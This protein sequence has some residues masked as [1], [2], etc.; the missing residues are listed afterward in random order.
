MPYDCK[1]D[2]FSSG[3]LKPQGIFNRPVLYPS[4]NLEMTQFCYIMD[5]N[6]DVLEKSQNWNGQVKS[7]I[8]PE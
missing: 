6:L 5:G 3:T 7:S 8:G 2:D 4:T 1:Q